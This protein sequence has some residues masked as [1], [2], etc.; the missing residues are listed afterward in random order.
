MRA[1][2]ELME[3]GSMT[4]LLEE[5]FVLSHLHPPHWAVNFLGWWSAFSSVTAALPH[6]I[7]RQFLQRLSFTFETL[8]WSDLLDAR[9]RNV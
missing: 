6:R 9:P 2:D 3:Y 7:N 8:E 4:C 1:V 5:F